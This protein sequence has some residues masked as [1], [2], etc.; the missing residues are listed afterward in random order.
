[1]KLPKGATILKVG[2]VSEGGDINGVLNVNN[3][4]DTVTFLTA[5]NAG[6]AEGAG[7]WYRVD[8][9]EKRT[10]RVSSTDTTRR[11]GFVHIQYV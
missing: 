6:S 10:I 7:L 3:H 8:S 1:M 2:F 9:E 4:N 11:K 5:S